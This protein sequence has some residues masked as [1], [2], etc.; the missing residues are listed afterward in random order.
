MNWTFNFAEVVIVDWWNIWVIVKLRQNDCE[1]Y[2]RSYNW[3]ITYKYEEIKK[4]IRHK[5]LTE[6]DK[7][8]YI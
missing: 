4:Y 8:Y 5:E 6:N 1:V 2:V 3:I 7:K